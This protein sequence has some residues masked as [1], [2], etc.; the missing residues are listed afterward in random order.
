MTLALVVH[1]SKRS[2]SLSREI[3]KYL[4][5]S[6]NMMHS[7]HEDVV[8][9]LNHAL[10]L[11]PSPVCIVGRRSII[12]SSTHREGS[13]AAWMEAV[14]HVAESHGFNIHLLKEAAAPLDESTEVKIIQ[15]YQAAQTKLQTLLQQSAKVAMAKKGAKFGR[16]PYGYQVVDGKLVIRPEQA[17][18]VVTVFQAYHDAI[19]MCEILYR[20]EGAKKAKSYGSRRKRESWNLKKIHRILDKVRLYGRGEIDS[21][22]GPVSFPE[23]VIL[24][25]HLV[26]TK[27]Q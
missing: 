21:P 26:C 23:L 16:P 7:D 10:T 3:S 9:A 20:V 1:G 22:L 19:P 14:N 4:E 13:K 6:G 25:P 15:D 27:R 11:R 12:V 17:A 8:D 5:D 18:N 2:P 24:P